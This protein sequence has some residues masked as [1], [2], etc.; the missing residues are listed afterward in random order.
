MRQV[1]VTVANVTLAVLVVSYLYIVALYSS[2]ISVSSESSDPTLAILPE[3]NARSQPTGGR[4]K[5]KLWYDMTSE[6]QDRS[7]RDASKYVTKYGAMIGEPTRFTWGEVV[8]LSPSPAGDG[9]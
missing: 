7:F 2:S 4:G 8:F 3:P 5:W 9:G 6:E 1:R